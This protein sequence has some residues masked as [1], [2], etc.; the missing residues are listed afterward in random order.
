MKA[1]VLFL[2]FVMLGCEALAQQRLYVRMHEAVYQVVDVINHYPVVIRNGK[3]QR[4]G[5]DPQYAL[6]EF[7][8]WLPG[9]VRVT[10][11][12]VEN[13]VLG[14]ES[15]PHGDFLQV[16]FVTT[17]NRDLNS[18]F[19]VIEAEPV[20]GPTQIILRQLPDLR[21]HQESRHAFKVRLPAR[22]VL[23]S[24]HVH[25]FSNGL[26]ITNGLLKN[27]PGPLTALQNDQPDFEMSDGP[28]HPLQRVTPSYP[29]QLRD[30]D[31][32]TLETHR[33]RIRVTIDE[34]GFVTKPEI[35]EATHWAAGEEA[36]RAALL[37]MFKPH[38]KDGQS[39]AIRVELP[40]TFRPQDPTRVPYGQSLEWPDGQR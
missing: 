2:F 19:V 22:F 29:P 8:Y 12:E 17:P 18:V 5:G 1:F 15:G 25:I 6:G 23:D 20:S 9:F 30:P 16:R 26:E 21:A 7:P 14:N 28:P 31:A 13:W 34:E 37:W 38:I 32:L 33:A 4:L 10:E 35:A 40:F 24:Y 3:R 39:Q 27:A 11:R 36:L